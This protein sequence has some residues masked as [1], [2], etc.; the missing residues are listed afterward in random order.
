MQTLLRACL[1]TRPSEE[2]VQA[3]VQTIGYHDKGK[4]FTVYT[5]LQF[6]T[7]AAAG[8]W[9]S[10]R[11]G[12]DYATHCGLPSVNSTFSKKAADVPYEVFNRLF[13]IV[14][15]KCNSPTRRKLR[16]PSALLLADSMTI[17]VGKMRLPWAVFHG[18]RS[19]VKLHVAYD[20]SANM[21]TWKK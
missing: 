8:Q 4:K 13:E 7:N 17:T 11:A 18:K 12:V 2:E 19:G 15:A 6:L 9:K 10:Y 20:P 5:L 21:P 14:V 1:Q 3:V 16:I